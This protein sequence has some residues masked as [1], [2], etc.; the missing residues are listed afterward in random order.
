MQSFWH[1]ALAAWL[2]GCASPSETTRLQRGCAVDAG[3]VDQCCNPCPQEL[4]EPCDGTLREFPNY[5]RTLRELKGACDDGYVNV[6]SGQCSSGVRVLFLGDG[7]IS[8]TRYFDASGNFLGLE[9]T[10]D[11][12]DP[13][14]QA[15][16]YFPEVIQCQAPTYHLI[17]SRSR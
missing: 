5:A 9:R 1:L 13:R 4:G 10:S 6:S 15:G 8:D 11:L 17:C 2:L 12:V 16:R 7:F 14:C 3:V